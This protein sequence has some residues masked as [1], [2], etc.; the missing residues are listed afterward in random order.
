MTSSKSTALDAQKLINLECYP[1]D[2]PGIAYDELVVKIRAQLSEHGCAVLRNFLSDEGIRAVRSEAGAVSHCGHKSHNRT[3]P[4][5]TQDDPELPID[6]PRR[7][8]FERSNYFIFAH[9]C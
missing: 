6:D 1:L 2:T 9:Y 3:N 8:F 4:Y 5:F 7:Q